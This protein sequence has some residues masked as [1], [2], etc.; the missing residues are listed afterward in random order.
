VA[1][2]KMAIASGVGA[3][4]T[5]DSNWPGAALFG[6]RAGRVVVGVR[7]SAVPRLRDA[8]LAAGCVGVHIGA[9][10]GLALIVTGNGDPVVLE[11]SALERAWRTAL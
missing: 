4:V 2:A 7:E 5:L 10:G 6:E 11:V 9:A 3:Q 8:L 1:L